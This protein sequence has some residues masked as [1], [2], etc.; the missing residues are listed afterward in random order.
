[1]RRIV[2]PPGRWAG[3]DDGSAAVEG[4]LALGLVLLAIALG[5]Q[6]VLFA[7]A[8]TVALAAAGAGA[9]SGAV[10]GDAAG[11]DDA[12]RFLAA[13]GGL[14]AGL[15]ATIG[16]DDGSVTAS[17]H[18]RAP[19]LFALALALPPLWLSV[20]SPLEQYPAGAGASS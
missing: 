16:Q 1:M 19:A 18:G 20:A 10:A 2:R 7:E 15:T 3:P 14:G 5:V 17:V 6:L 9:R 13:S 11:L 12:E 8:R 4:V